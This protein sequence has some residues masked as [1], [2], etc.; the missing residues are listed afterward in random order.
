MS[1]FG[2]YNLAVE[3][4]KELQDKYLLQ[5]SEAIQ[6]RDLDL[7]LSSRDKVLA[8]GLGISLL[9]EKR[10]AERIRFEEI[11]QAEGNLSRQLEMSHNFDDD[12][13]Y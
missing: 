6:A 2:S 5:H 8:L 10:E 7:E 3:L 12:T 9:K 4:L 11:H 1:I 13:P